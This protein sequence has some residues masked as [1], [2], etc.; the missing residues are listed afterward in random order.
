[1]SWEQNR[2]HW[3]VYRMFTGFY[4]AMPTGWGDDYVKGPM[5]WAEACNQVNRVNAI[6]SFLGPEINEKTFDEILSAYPR[7]LETFHHLVFSQ[8]E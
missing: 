5:D 2:K 8:N 6:R 4:S 7:M 3:A 1:M